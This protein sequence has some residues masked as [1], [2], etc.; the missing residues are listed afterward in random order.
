MYRIVQTVVVQKN[1]LNYAKFQARLPA[2]A[3]FY[4]ISKL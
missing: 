4:N 3:G 1:Y 2:E